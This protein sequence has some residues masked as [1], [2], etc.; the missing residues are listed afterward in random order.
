VSDN[1]N[2]PSTWSTTENVEWVT[3]VPG[4]GWSSPIV[5]NGKVFVTS[6]VSEAPMKQPSL[7][8]DLSND[9]VAE[10][11]QQG[12]S[13]GEI[14]AK[15]NERDAEFPDEVTLVYSLFCMDLETGKLLWRNDFFKGNPPAGRHRKNSYTSQTPVTDGET[16]YVYVA[17]L[18]LY[19][20]DMAGNDQWQIPLDKHQVYLDFGGGASPALH[21]DR[22]FILNDN[23]E[24]SFVAGY[25]GKTGE[26]LW[27]TLRP[28]M[29]SSQMKSAWSSPFV[30]E[31]ELRTEV[32]TIEPG[33]VISYDL[34]GTELWRMAR[35]AQFAIARP[36][37]YDGMLY[38]TSGSQGEPNKPMAAIRPGGSGE[39]TPAEGT[40][41]N[42]FV[43]W[44]DRVAGGTYLPT[45]VIADAGIFS[46]HDPAMGKR[47][48]RS[49]IHPT[50]R[51]LTSSP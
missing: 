25:D 14:M 51:N 10:L 8:V 45:P 47:L 6:A 49:R 3:V 39:I 7:G 32:V 28:G 50:A 34:D 40:T 26:H 37:A 48:Y 4:V 9:Y 19:V 27:T 17:F 42:D 23:Q 5:W 43:A 20:F 13:M 33:F 16:V 30:W 29:G 41:A 46:K 36:F 35:M 2:L 24:D 1:P 12:L 15:V 18:G 44:Y 11:Q 21:D 38:V 22:L 31:N